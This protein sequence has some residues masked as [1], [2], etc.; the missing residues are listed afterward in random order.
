M[1]KFTTYLKEMQSNSVVASF[2]RMSPPTVG[3]GLL[4]KKVIET[5][6]KNK[7]DHVIYLSRSFDPKKNPLPIDLKLKWAK[8]MFPG[9]NLKPADDS[10]QTF[11]DMVIA[12]NTVY[13]TLYMIA[14]S[15][16]VAEYQKIL[17]KYNGVEY[18]YDK[19]VVVSAGERDPDADGAAGMSATKMREAAKSNNLST[20]K[21]GLPTHLNLGD[22]Q[23]MMDDVRKGM[24]L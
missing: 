3:H 17:D 21:Q 14:G 15:D 5:A 4:V 9:V 24:N 23:K 11:I 10:I 13:K 22:A 2:G 12:L 8:K 6:R 16:R 20:F 19:I 1:I 7:A 18:Q